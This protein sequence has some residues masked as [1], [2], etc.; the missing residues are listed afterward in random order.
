[1]HS[2]YPADATASRPWGQVTEK[3]GP[4]SPGCKSAGPRRDRKNGGGWK[5]PR[6][7]GGLVNL[8]ACSASRA[9]G[10]ATALLRGGRCRACLPAS[11]PTGLAREAVTVVINGEPAVIEVERGTRY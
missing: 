7:V 6:G 5:E 11:P 8:T 10:L 3:V 9:V 4:A 2:G 1:M